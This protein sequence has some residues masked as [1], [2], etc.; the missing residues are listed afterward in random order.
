MKRLTV[1]IIVFILCLTFVACEVNNSNSENSILKKNVQKGGYIT[2]GKYEQDNDLSNG[3]EEIEWLV[4]DV[5]DGK[6]LVISKHALDY[7]PYNDVK[8]QTMWEICSLRT[9][10]NNDFCNNAF[11]QDEKTQIAFT[12]IP[13]DMNGKHNAE[14]DTMDKVFVLS[15]TEAKKYF[16]SD[17]LRKCNPTEYAIAQGS[18]VKNSEGNCSWWL[19][20]IDSTYM[21]S[22]AAVTAGNTWGGY[23]DEYGYVVNSRCSVRPAMWIDLSKIG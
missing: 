11:S 23:V 4:L 13:N 2:L 17:D 3:K 1:M 7:Q 8:E 18:I 14:F 9:W 12:T 5:E 10:L 21:S 6:A 16:D 22:A 19:R 15:V 20:T